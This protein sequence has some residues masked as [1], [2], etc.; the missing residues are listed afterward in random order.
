MPV[1]AVPAEAAG[2]IEVSVSMDRLSAQDMGAASAQW[3]SEFL[4]PPV[5]LVRFDP[6][7]RG[8]FIPGFGKEI[9]HRASNF[10]TLFRS[11]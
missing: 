11:S 9:L 1:L 10:Q 5:K 8:R 7:Q 3:L 4:G 2:T 6:A